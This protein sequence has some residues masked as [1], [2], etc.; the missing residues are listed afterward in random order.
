MD[1]GSFSK[2]LVSM[3][4]RELGQV[5]C[6]M[7]LEVAMLRETSRCEADRLLD[8]KDKDAPNGHRW[9]GY[10]RKA[11]NDGADMISKHISPR[12]GED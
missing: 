6:H 12:R 2:L 9:D 8:A 3:H 4:F 7:A 5:G 11:R 10:R 1:L